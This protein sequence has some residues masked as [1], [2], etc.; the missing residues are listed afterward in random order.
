MGFLVTF[1]CDGGQSTFYEAVPKSGRG[2]PVIVLQ[3]WW[4]IVPHI[5]QVCD[6]LAAEQFVAIAPDL[7]HGRA[8]STPDEASRLM[9]ALDINRAAQDLRAAIRYL[10]IGH[11]RVSGKRVG[12]VG[13]CM[14]GQLSLFAASRF[15]E[16]G[17]CVDFYGI[18]PRVQVDY[19]KISC[20]VMGCFAEKDSHVP[21]PAARD[22]ESQLKAHGVKTDVHIFPGV[23]HAFF[24]DSRPEVYNQA[25]AQ[26]AW[27]STLSFLR[28]SLAAQLVG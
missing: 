22:L 6:R 10:I 19:S 4:G 1:D 27:E 28:E 26:V 23:E 8:A 25:T 17:A 15:P 14:G 11:R 20:P 5:K 9:M 21:P 12:V 24:N 7:Y 13:F 2:L 3:E 16:I 18:H